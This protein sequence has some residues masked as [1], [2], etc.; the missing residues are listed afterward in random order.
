MALTIEDRAYIDFTLNTAI[1]AALKRNREQFQKDTERYMGS[2]VEL[3]RD[4][5]KK[6]MEIAS[7]RP[8]EERVREIVRE[9]VGPIVREEVNIYV[10][11]CL[12]E[13]VEAGVAPLRKDI[14]DLKDEMCDLKGEMVALR[15][16]SNR[17]DHEIKALKLK[18]A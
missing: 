14:H 7:A 16:D 8:T 12:R 10:V 3:F 5:I 4:D 2:L 11:P 17:H 13:A 18:S 15:K 9:E 6:V 1:E